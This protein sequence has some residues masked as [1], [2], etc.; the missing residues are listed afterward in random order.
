MLSGVIELS[1][2]I[3]CSNHT[4]RPNN[5]LISELLYYTN[6]KEMMDSALKVVL[7]VMLKSIIITST[8]HIRPQLKLHSLQIICTFMVV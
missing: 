8:S 3:T 4:A 7:F 6:A 2:Q 1:F 5:C